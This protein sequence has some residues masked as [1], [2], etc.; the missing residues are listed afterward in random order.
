MEK[1]FVP[2]DDTSF[3]Q[4]ERTR[5]EDA[6]GERKERDSEG[7][8]LRSQ[9]PF[10]SNA[11]PASSPTLITSPKKKAPDRR[12]TKP[13]AHWEMDST[14][15][16]PGTHGSRP[17]LVPVDTFSGWT[18]TFP[19]THEMSQTVVKKVLEDIL[20]GYGL[21]ALLCPDNG[22]AFPFSSF[23]SQAIMLPKSLFAE[24]QLRLREAC[25]QLALNGK[26]LPAA[27]AWAERQRRYF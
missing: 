2:K 23:C 22:P 13:G 1:G 18:E 9:T 25:P 7:P 15:E 24:S 17:T 6:D 12:G 19:T 21:P 11:S 20:P 26:K 10:R 5:D 3:H 16:K 8:G 4:E 27:K 14:E